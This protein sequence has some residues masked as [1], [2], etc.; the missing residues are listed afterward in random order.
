MS[1]TQSS[2]DGVNPTKHVGVLLILAALAVIVLGLTNGRMVAEKVISDMVMPCGLVWLALT[3]V[4]YFAVVG[5]QRFLFLLSFLAWLFFTLSSN[6]IVASYLIKGLEEEHLDTRPL[7][8]NEP[9]DLVVVLGGG[10]VTAPNAEL[11]LGLSGDRIALAAR[12]YHAERTKKIVCTGSKI[13]GLGRV[14]QLDAGEESRAILE[15]L[16]VPTEVIETIPGR[17]TREEIQHLAEFLAERPDSRV[18]LLT[19]AWHLRRATGLAK[20]AGLDVEPVPADF[21]TNTQKLSVRSFVPSET[22]LLDTRLALHEYLGAL[23][24]R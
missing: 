16:G 20:A 17:N 3:M 13:A 11:Q 9:Y 21:K 18:G 23:L 8:I 19:S 22:A 2:S 24:G 14:N 6:G 1:Q 7:L 15:G 4:C 10:S 5:G 12:M